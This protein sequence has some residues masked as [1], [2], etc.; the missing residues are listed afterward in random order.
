MIHVGSPF[1][2]ALPHHPQIGRLAA[3]SA[4]TQFQHAILGASGPFARPTH[5][6]GNIARLPPIDYRDMPPR[7][8]GTTA[9]PDTTVRPE[10]RRV[11]AAK[12]A[13]G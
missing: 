13:T 8:K 4:P 6:L 7:L 12:N 3:A 1:V 11:P 5:G 2:C 9:L 10:T